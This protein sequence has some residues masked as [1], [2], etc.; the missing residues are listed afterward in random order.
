MPGNSTFIIWQSCFLNIITTEYF[1]LDGLSS[2]FLKV[3]CELEQFGHGC[4]GLC[5]A[6]H[7]VQCDGSDNAVH[8]V[9]R[10]LDLSRGNKRLVEIGKVGAG[11]KGRLEKVARMVWVGLPSLLKQRYTT[12]WVP[13]G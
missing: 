4:V 9:S 3:E 8:K 2:L 6:A 10:Q 1:T 7:V 13:R 12:F 11:Q 5:S